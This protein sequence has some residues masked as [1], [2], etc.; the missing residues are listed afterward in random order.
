M[1]PLCVAYALNDFYKKHFP[2]V[3]PINTTGELMAGERSLSFIDAFFLVNHSM[4]ISQ[5]AI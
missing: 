3:R 1:L 2:K 4:N 5:D